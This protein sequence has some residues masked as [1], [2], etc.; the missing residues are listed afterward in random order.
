M[1]LRDY[2][3]ILRKSWI[4][5]VV[6][7]LAGVAGAATFSILQTPRYSAESRVFVSTE[8]GGTTSELVQGSTFTQARVK[9]YSSLVETPIVL[10]PV[11]SSLDLELTA[12]E[13]AESIEASAPLDTTLIVITVT[14][15]DPVLA[16]DIANATSQS[17][18]AVVEE[19]ETT[20]G[21][22][23]S[24]VRL[25]RVQDATVPTAPVSPNIPLNIALGLLVGLAIGV[26]VAVLREVL[27]NRIR[28]ERD[29]ELITDV[30]ILGGIGFDPNA[31]A[32][33]LIVQVDP[34]SPRAESFRT[35]RTNLQFVDIER[36]S[37]AFVVTSALESEG[38][39]TTAAN[40]AIAMADA[41]FRVL[42]VDADLRRPKLANY[43]DLEG[44]VGLTDV[45]IGRAKLADVVQ[46]WG[47]SGFLWVL[48]AG[49]VPPNPS[50]LLG[51]QA[52]Q[53]LIEVF[54]EQFDVVLFD[55]PPLLPVTDA[56]VLAKKVGGTILV[57]AAGRTQR[58][59]LRGALMTLDN[60]GSTVSGIVLTMLPTKGPDAY[61]YAR[62]GY[63]GYGAGQGVE[64]G[65]TRA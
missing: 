21:S 39:S 47:R 31:A 8:S 4:L 45:L 63:Y 57:V 58:N 13:L 5:I 23:E 60:V 36:A 52:M 50:E 44:A 19:I 42:I 26:G 65:S 7:A 43:M 11:L 1:E 59:Q 46:A 38:K 32:R 33:P 64:S 12:D 17:L 35:L 27:D 10:L 53:R 51:S 16:A 34:L 18:T 30:P 29:V 6:L 61:G 62:Y 24:P 22:S 40:L 25:T 56:A 48:P 49:M 9:T 28:N 15:P 20:P 2:L 41:G 55:S 14:D 54:A 3:R 37:R